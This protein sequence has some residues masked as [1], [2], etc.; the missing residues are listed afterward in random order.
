MSLHISLISFA[1]LNIRFGFTGLNCIYTFK[2]FDIYCLMSHKNYTH[3][4]PI[5][6]NTEYYH[7]RNVYQFDR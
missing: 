7:L 2:D 5:C 1:P 4:I 3:P 6:A